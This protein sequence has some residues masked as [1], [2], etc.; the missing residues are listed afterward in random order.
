MISKQDLCSLHQVSVQY[1]EKNV[2]AR[3]YRERLLHAAGF[4]ITASIYSQKLL[5]KVLLNTEKLLHAAS[6]Y[7][8]KLF[9]TQKPWPAGLL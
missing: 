1:L 3:L 8:H 7:A 5:A 4:Q 6:L 2:L 9:F